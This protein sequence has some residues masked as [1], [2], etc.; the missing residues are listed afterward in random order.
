MK[1]LILF[2]IC[3]FYTVNSL[4]VLQ[5]NRTPRLPYNLAVQK[6][7]VSNA[8]LI[9]GFFDSPDLTTTEKTIW[10]GPGIYVYPTAAV[11]MTISSSDVDDTAAGAGL[12]QVLINGLDAN[13]NEISETII[14]NGQT[15]VTTVNSYFRIQGTGMIGTA[16]GA[17][18][19]NEGIIYIGVGTVTTGVPATIYN[20]ISIGD[21]SSHSE[22]CSLD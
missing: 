10:A 12:Q 2:F 6:G 3:L 4:A 22:E 11:Q 5:V 13:Y 1:N 19:F 15:P 18:E 14:L 20:L 16:A 7:L 17:S 9:H 21:N 8:R